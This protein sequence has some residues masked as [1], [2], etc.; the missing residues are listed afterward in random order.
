MA[1]TADNLTSQVLRSLG[2]WLGTVAALVGVVTW[3]SGWRG[4]HSLVTLGLLVVLVFASDWKVSP[5]L[6][7]ALGYVLVANWSFARSDLEEAGK[8]YA[9]AAR[10]L[11]KVVR[12][13]DNEL[14][15]L[16][17]AHDQRWRLLTVLDRHEDALPAAREAADAWRAAV[18]H[19]TARTPQLA[20]ALN[21]L[22][23]TLGQ[24]D[25][26]ADAIPI[27][28]EAIT[29]NRQQV[30]LHEGHLA[31][32]LAN[33]VISLSDGEHWERALPP[34]EEVW[35]IRRR[36]A[37]SDPNLRDEVT[38]DADRLRRVLYHLDRPAEIL[39]VSE[40]LVDHERALVADDPDRLPAYAEAVRW[41]GTS[42]VDVD[43]VPEA[44]TRWYEA[45]ELLRSFSD[46]NPAARPS[47]AT[48]CERVGHTLGP[49]GA[50]DE[51]LAVIRT[52]LAIRRTLADEDD[53]HH[54]ELV[55]ALAGAAL[56]LSFCGQPDLARQFAAEGLALYR[57][58]PETSGPPQ[59]LQVLEEHA[60]EESDG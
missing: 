21:R 47:Y 22:A 48:M 17:T 51:T 52:G 25:R 39:H 42:L 4:G 11:R 36:L 55:R 18:A 12:Y 16:A 41:L 10:R 60:G 29:V 1:K 46:S 33:L 19:D 5:H 14:W 37:V 43:R 58:N 50:T 32:N 15:R 35:T 9:K 38:D 13:R 7:L 54:Q 3:I 24:L 28:E 26:E 44:K 59:V 49:L 8:Y 2:A 45:L 31:R 34:A 30:T 27:T 20:E 6:G 53:Q 56:R 57:Q 23:V 40:S